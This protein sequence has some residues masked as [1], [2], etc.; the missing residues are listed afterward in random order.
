[1][2]RDPKAPTE[3]EAERR[4]RSLRRSIHPELCAR[5]EKA[6]AP[7]P[8]TST[9]DSAF[10]EDGLKPSPPR[11]CKAGVPR[12]SHCPQ[13]MGMGRPH[14]WYAAKPGYRRSPQAEKA[15][16]DPGCRPTFNSCARQEKGIR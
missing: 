3:R 10:G 6:A 8:T 5:R 2:S 1:M 16:N 14:A 12:A 15:G 13:P 9:A 7:V 11:D 4:N